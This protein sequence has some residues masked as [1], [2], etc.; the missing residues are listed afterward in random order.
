MTKIYTQ[1]TIPGLHYYPDAPEDVDFLA[2]THRHLF[3]IKV[4]AKVS[5]DNRELEFFQMQDKLR[6][7]INL[8]YDRDN[9]GFI[10]EARSC[11]MIAKD[12]LK[13][14]PTLNSVEVSEDN[15]S[16]AVVYA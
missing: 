12:I 4:T 16:G 5:H 10:F 8:T 15:E 14:W 6:R 2:H 9:H 3:T 7:I 1:I 11:E 13:V